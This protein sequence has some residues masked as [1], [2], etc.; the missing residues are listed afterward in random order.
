M[1]L[2][3]RIIRPIRVQARI[4]VLFQPPC[5]FRVLFFTEYTTQLLILK[6]CTSYSR[7]ELRESYNV[8]AELGNLDS[9]VRVMRQLTVKLT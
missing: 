5:F 3:V 1:R 2:R 4:I 6:F 7:A 9:S 8:C